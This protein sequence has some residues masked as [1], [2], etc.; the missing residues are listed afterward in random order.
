M[1]VIGGLLAGALFV[2]ICLAPTLIL[3]LRAGPSGEDL[4]AIGAF[5]NSA[6][7][8]ANWLLPLLIAVQA[9]LI[10]FLM[11]QQV[12]RLSGDDDY[13]AR[14]F[15]ATCCFWLGSAAG[16]I[17]VAAIVA[18]SLSSDA[19][20]RVFAI[21]IGCILS[22]V[23]AAGA[24]A[25]TPL[26]PRDRL[27]YAHSRE[28]ATVASLHYLRG[29]EWK[30][31]DDT[32]IPRRTRLNALAVCGAWA[33]VP[34]LAVGGLW[35]VLD[36]QSSLDEG[37]LQIFFIGF[38]TSVG[39]AYPLVTM[40]TTRPSP[41]RALV[42]CVLTVVGVV[43]GLG[44]SLVASVLNACLGLLIATGYASLIIGAL[45]PLRVPWLPIAAARELTAS[46]ELSE[47]RSVRSRIRDLT[48]PPLQESLE[49]GAEPRHSG[50]RTGV[51]KILSSFSGRL[52]RQ[53][54]SRQSH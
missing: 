38:A 25:M 2:G 23:L 46:M 1:T 22:L 4:A 26:D 49:S 13:R 20:P 15:V 19:R 45:L 48:P 10:A 51:A 30:S 34:W 9:L 53:G 54:P 6:V 32:P 52:R 37:G 14:Q 31:Q 41:L 11:G 39:L 33:T 17:L 8:E 21:V 47:L 44:V 5:I 7:N 42:I 3:A 35:V 50:R 28:Q 24:N 29:P 12:S 27:H 18:A 40:W 43:L 36:G 16:A